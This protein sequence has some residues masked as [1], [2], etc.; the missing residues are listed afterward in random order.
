MY[1]FMKDVKKLAQ[2]KQWH[3]GVYMSTCQLDRW[4][5]VWLCQ[6]NFIPLWNSIVPNKY[7]LNEN[8]LMS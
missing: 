6:F 3:V 5:D 7:S 1:V 2:E 4:Q 8:E